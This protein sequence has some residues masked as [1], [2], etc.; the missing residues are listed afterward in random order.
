MKISIDIDCSAA[1]ARAFFGLP[2]IEPFQK[3]ILKQLQKRMSEHLQAMNPEELMKVWMPAGIRA[4]ER[5][6]EQF[7]AQF[8]AAGRPS[9]KTKK[10]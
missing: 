4:W 5:M 6:Q 10:T 9:G 3:E 1:E 8:A 7:M 2:D